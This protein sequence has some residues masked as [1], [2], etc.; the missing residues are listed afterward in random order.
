[1]YGLRGRGLRRLASGLEAI[2]R[3][4][5]LGVAAGGGLP[6][7]NCACAN[8]QQA[9]GGVLPPQ[10]QSSVAVGDDDGNWFLINA[11]PDLPVQM[12]TY[13]AMS[14]HTGSSRNS[15]IAG[16]FL[17]S[18]DVDHVLGLLS[19]R[20]G[21]TLHIYTTPAIQQA[22]EILGVTTVLQ[23]FSGVVWHHPADGCF[24]TL[25][26]RDGHESS[27]RVRALPLSGRAPRYA[28][29]S[30]AEDVGTMALQFLDERTG[31]RLLVAPGVA[32]WSEALQEIA[33]TSDAVL[34][35]G[36]FWSEDEL[37]RVRP[38]A[39]TAADMG[40]LPINDGTLPFM[41]ALPSR[42]RVYVHINNTNPIFVPGSP[43]RAAVE[44]AGVIIGQD[45][46]SFDL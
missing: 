40:H 36:T 7:W 24:P 12:R 31:G 11:S 16:A 46:M 8:C 14:P 25:R 26:G 39:P 9:R 45:G 1:V 38:G 29:K 18:A 42:H 30:C 15:P 13:P 17:T 43:E 27:L 22:A 4:L 34:I 35:D 37:R 41:R 33:T 6:Q 28:G 19:L 20:E 21:N 2:I 3:V 23:S 44:S 32:A 10:T 5:L